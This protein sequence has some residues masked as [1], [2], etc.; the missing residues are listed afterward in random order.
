MCFIVICLYLAFG[1][2][3]GY[4]IAEEKDWEDEALILFPI[5]MAFLWPIIGLTAAL[6][7]LIRYVHKIANG[8][9]KK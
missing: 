3:L 2:A 8:G 9:P 7:C 5:A 1:G 4:Y 6:Y